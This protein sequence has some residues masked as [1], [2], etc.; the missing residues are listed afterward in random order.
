MKRIIISLFTITILTI[1]CFAQELPA[2]QEGSGMIEDIEQSYGFDIDEL[3]SLGAED[4]LGLLTEAVLSGTREPVILF[5]TL[6]MMLIFASIA[7]SISDSKDGVTKTVDSVLNIVFF[8]VLV[9]PVVALQGGLEEAI[10]NCKDFLN[11]FLMV[12]V[13]LL[14][15]SGQPGTAA[16]A[17]S[18]FA[19]AIIIVAEILTQVVL[20]L[21]SVYLSIKCC[22]L[23]VTSVEFGGIAEI[24]RKLL[25]YILVATTTLFTAVMAMQSLISSAADSLAL[26]TGKF[27]V[28]NAVPIVGSVLQE[29]ITTV[30]GGVSALKTTA[31]VAAIVAV[32]IIFVPLFLQ[33]IAY[34]LM[35][36]LTGVMAEISGS[37]KITQ[38]MKAAAHTM[39]IFFSCIV[40]FCLMIIVSLL[41]FMLSGGAV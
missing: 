31:G 41:T 34:I 24:I 21:A 1:G 22:S 25:R 33:C 26:R 35:F 3:L 28:G 4:Y 13:A 16:V 9:L 8:L 5:V 19:A 23:S 39:E 14:A 36:E 40:L 37:V 17:S 29:A 12:F 38:L 7:R 20:P 18:F 30:L 27:I 11:S 6:S 2:Q 10:L 15:T 32:V